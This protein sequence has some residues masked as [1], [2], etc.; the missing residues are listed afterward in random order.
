MDESTRSRLK[1]QGEDAE[2]FFDWVFVCFM[3]ICSWHGWPLTLSLFLWTSLLSL[4]HSPNIHSRVQA[5]FLDLI[6]FPISCCHLSTVLLVTWGS[7]TPQ[8]ILWILCP[9]S[10]HWEQVDFLLFL[11][12]FFFVCLCLFVLEKRN[13]DSLPLSANVPPEVREHTNGK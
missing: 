10:S 8:P 5:G 4:S 13:D 9:D 2:V 11:F 6:S 12:L 1:E 7:M 3:S